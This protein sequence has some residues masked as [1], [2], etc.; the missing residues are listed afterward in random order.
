MR[1]E[2][3]DYGTRLHPTKR[4]WCDAEQETWKWNLVELD[5]STPELVEGWEIDLVAST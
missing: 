1:C 4:E 2:Q 3:L 5:S